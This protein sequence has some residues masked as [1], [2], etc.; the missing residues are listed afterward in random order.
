MHFHS[1]QHALYLIVPLVP[2]ERSPVEP[3]RDVAPLADGV[4][5]RHQIAEHQTLVGFQAHLK[6]LVVVNAGIII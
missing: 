6:S 3:V 1:L 4:E 2:H 5:H